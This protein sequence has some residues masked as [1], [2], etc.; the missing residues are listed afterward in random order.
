M[1]WMPVV[2][3]ARLRSSSAIARVLRTAEAAS[4]WSSGVVAYFSRNSRPRW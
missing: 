1:L 3:A 2:L 4:S